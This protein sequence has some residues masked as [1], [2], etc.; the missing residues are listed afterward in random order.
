M[1]PMIKRF[2]AVD[3]NFGF[4]KSCGLYD[5]VEVVFQTYEQ[6]LEWALNLPEGVTLLCDGVDPAYLLQD[7]TSA[8]RMRGQD[9]IK[10]H[11]E[12]VMLGPPRRQILVRPHYLQ[13]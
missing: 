7:I 5:G 2:A 1:T 12:G 11:C 10:V 9:T 8:R 4:E 3:L 6:V 13:L